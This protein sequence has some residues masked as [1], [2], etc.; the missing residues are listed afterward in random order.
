[1]LLREAITSRRAVR[2]YAPTPIPDAV[3]AEVLRLTQRAPTAYNMQP[4]SV[5][6][7]RDQ[8]DR[9]KIVDAMLGPNGDKVK[10]APVVVVFA[11]D[12]RPSQRVPRI[13]KLLRDNGTPEMMVDYIPEAVAMFSGDKIYSPNDELS[14]EPSTDPKTLAWAYKQTTFAAATFLYTAHASGLVTSPMEGFDGA[15]LRAALEIPDRYSI[16]VVISC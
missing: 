4:Y 2:A 15:K 7:L 13:Q 8:A 1:A 12:T 5:V 3:L 10:E 14:D 11:A 6:V 16:P 9:E